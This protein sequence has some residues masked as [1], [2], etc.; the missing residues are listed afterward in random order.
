M[1]CSSYKSNNTVLQQCYMFSSTNSELLIMLFCMIFRIKGKG[2]FL[3]FTEKA[4]CCIC[5]LEG[6][7]I[8]WADHPRGCSA[9]SVWSEAALSHVRFLMFV[10]PVELSC[11][12]GEHFQGSATQVG[13]GGPCREA[14]GKRRGC[15][16]MPAH[17]EGRGFSP[18]GVLTSSAR[19]IETVNVLF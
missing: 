14:S 15:L 18:S 3:F 13:Y 16:S 10:P 2:F 6:K 19:D 17:W 12:T 11:K 8:F 5:E 4:G 9:E 7:E 1:S